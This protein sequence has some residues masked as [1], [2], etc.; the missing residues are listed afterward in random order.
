MNVFVGL[1]M[2][3]DCTLRFKQNSINTKTKLFSE[4]KLSKH[5]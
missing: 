5:G 2:L 3:T 4:T 1:P